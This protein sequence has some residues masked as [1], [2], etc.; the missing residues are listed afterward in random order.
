MNYSANVS[1]ASYRWVTGELQRG[2]KWEVGS[3]K[4]LL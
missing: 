2:G 3:G 1:R 4:R